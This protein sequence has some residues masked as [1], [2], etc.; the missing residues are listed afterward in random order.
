MN[1][2][3]MCLCCTTLRGVT[4]FMVNAHLMGSFVLFLVSL[5]SYLFQTLAIPPGLEDVNPIFVQNFPLLIGGY[6]LVACLFSCFIYRS[7][8]MESLFQ[9]TWSVVSFAGFQFLVIF[10]H[11]VFTVMFRDLVSTPW[12][13]MMIGVLI[14]NFGATVV[15]LTVLFLYGKKIHYYKNNQSIRNSIGNNVPFHSSNLTASV[16]KKQANRNPDLNLLE[17]HP[18]VSRT[19]SVCKSTSTDDDL[20][21]G[22]NVPPPSY[23]AS[24]DV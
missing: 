21:N 1:Y 17:N 10:L 6:A 12:Q 14:S 11:L 4:Y 9:L 13:V 7:I 3:I 18:P 20:E 24:P 22:E 16:L 15:Y 19:N 8:D 2:T 5:H 23:S